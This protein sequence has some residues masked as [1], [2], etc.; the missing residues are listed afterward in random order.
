MGITGGI[1]LIGAGDPEPVD[2]VNGDSAS[3]IVL[4][5]E[6]AGR[7]VP[8]RLGDLGVSEHVLASH[9]G[10]DIGAEVLARKL[11]DI[12]AAPLVIQAYSRLVID[13]NRPPRSP[14]AVPLASDGVRIPGNWVADEAEC[15]A[16]AD[17]IFEPMDR[18][19]DD[20]FAARTRKAAFSVHSF[21]PRMNS[22]VR[23]W[24]A[25]FVS[26]RDLATA[27]A[28]IAYM[29]AA[30][31]DL[32]LALN[33]PYQ[34]EAES[35][36]FIPHHVESRNLRHCLI[37]IRNDQLG[38]DADAAAWAGLLAKAIRHVMKEPAA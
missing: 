10:W 18:A 4:L 3:E 24:H 35:D 21:A 17:E 5:C 11:A 31:P 26:R 28:L 7:A 27:N 12:L 14:L 30:R 9:R 29:G 20:L 16:R 13:C 32:N 37:E 15:S 23:P 6:H 2:V 38:E 25:G 19:I 36:W 33:Q 34:I 22:R 1:T 8:E